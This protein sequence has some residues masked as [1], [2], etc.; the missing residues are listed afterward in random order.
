MKATLEFNLP[1]EAEEFRVA[2]DG[3]AWKSVVWDLYE[4][5]RRWSKYG[6]DT[7]PLLM[8]DVKIMTE[9]LPLLNTLMEDKGLTLE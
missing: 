3:G 6:M 8:E 9:I 7:E 4:E 1:E 2:Q 5:L